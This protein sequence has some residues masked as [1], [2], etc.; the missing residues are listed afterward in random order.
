MSEAS[1][2]KATES[3]DVLGGGSYEVLKQ[4]LE[5]FGRKLAT[6]IQDLNARRQETF[7]GSSFDNLGTE[8]VHTEN[9]CKPVDIVNVNGELLVGYEVRR[10]R[11]QEINVGDALALHQFQSTGIWSL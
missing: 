7:G 11:D 2:D 6:K 9:R 10:F 3:T 8:H 5:G 4:R 1:S